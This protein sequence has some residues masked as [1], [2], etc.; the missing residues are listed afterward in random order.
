MPFQIHALPAAQFA[1][2]FTLDD[3]ALAARNARRMTVNEHPGVPCRVS[4]ADAEVGETVLLVNHCHLDV[5]SPYRAFHAIYVRETAVQAQPPRGAVPD[6]LQRRLI[7]LR[8]FDTDGM[9]VVAEVLEG[10]ALADALPK[11][12]DDR[13]VDVVHLHYAKPGCYAARVTR[14]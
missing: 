3:T 7:S 12:F 14:T 13:S 1:P 10:T 11:V 8:G 9:M 6:V 2:L 5:A 4:L